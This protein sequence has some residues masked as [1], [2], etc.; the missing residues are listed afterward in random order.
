MKNLKGYGSGR[1]IFKTASLKNQRKTTEVLNQGNWLPGRRSATTRIRPLH[2]NGC[3]DMKCLIIS[4]AWK[5][6]YVSTKASSMKY[7]RKY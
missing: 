2:R 5:Y 6:I 3:W 4:W 1:G 7:E